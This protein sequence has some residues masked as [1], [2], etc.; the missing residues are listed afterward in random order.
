[1]RNESIKSIIEMLYYR[2]IG[3]HSCLIAHTR[4]R[5]Y[6]NKHDKNA[7]VLWP[8]EIFIS[9]EIM[10]RLHIQASHEIPPF[11]DNEF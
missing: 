1:M 7:Q 3:K 4:H 5:R 9:L 2:E 6:D 8:N 11:S 10:P